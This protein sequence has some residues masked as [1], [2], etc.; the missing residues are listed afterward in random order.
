MVSKDQLIQ[1]VKDILTA[2]SKVE[3]TYGDIRPQT[4]F[5]DNN[6]V[7]QLRFI[8]WEGTKH[9]YGSVI[10]VEVIDDKIWIHHD[11]TEKGVAVELEEQGVPKNQIVL[12][13]IPP[14]RRQH[15]DY[16]VA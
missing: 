4:I 9:V 15:T 1:K 5:D 16:A 8:G 3:F 13:W 12:G 6:N 14:F 11:G 10:D 2:H 7:Y